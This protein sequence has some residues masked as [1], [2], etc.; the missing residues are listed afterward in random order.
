MINI[1]FFAPS[2]LFA[3]LYMTALGTDDISVFRTVLSL[4]NNL[5]EKTKLYAAEHFSP[6]AYAFVSRLMDVLVGMLVV[7]VCAKKKQ[8]ALIC[9]VMNI[10]MVK[11]D[12][13]LKECNFWTYTHIYIYIRL[14]FLFVISTFPYGGRGR[15]YSCIIGLAVCPSCRIRGRLSITSM[16]K[17][18]HYIYR[19]EREI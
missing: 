11:C 3:Q 18:I 19:K 2:L 13:L 1:L 5:H 7:N 17:I 16:E 12:M 14:R 8:I 15:Y 10:E 6:I 9:D 4:V